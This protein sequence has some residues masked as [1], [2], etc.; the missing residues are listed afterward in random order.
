VQLLQCTKLISWESEQKTFNQ[1]RTTGYYDEQHR[2]IHRTSH[3]WESITV[4]QD[5]SNVQHAKLFFLSLCM[6]GHKLFLHIFT[7]ATTDKIKRVKLPVSIQYILSNQAAQKDWCSRSMVS[8]KADGNQMVLPY[9]QRWCEMDNQATTP[10]GCC[11]S[12][13]FL[14]VRPH[15]V[16]ARWNRYQDLNSFPL[17]WPEKTPTYYVDKVYPVRPEIQ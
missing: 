17:G 2:Q 14:P 10:F 16:N 6:T 8:A 15:C 12:M 9:A 7:N 5:K 11:S 3:E 13:A 1:R 4:A